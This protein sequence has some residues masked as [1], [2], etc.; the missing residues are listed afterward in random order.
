MNL[1]NITIHLYDL[2]IDIV[3]AWCTHFDGFD[4]FKF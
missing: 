4:N 1:K 2:N 3:D